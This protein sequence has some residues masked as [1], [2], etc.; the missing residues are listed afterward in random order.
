[1]KLPVQTQARPRTFGYLVFCW[2]R[3]LLAGINI[4]YKHA[5]TCI[6]FY[7]L[8]DIFS[9]LHSMDVLVSNHPILILTGTW[10]TT[11]FI[12]HCQEVYVQPYPGLLLSSHTIH[13]QVHYP[14]SV[15]WKNVAFADC[16]SWPPL[17]ETRVEH[18]F[19]FKWITEPWAQLSI[20][21]LVWPILTLNPLKLNP[22]PLPCPYSS[23]HC[24]IWV[25]TSIS[26]DKRYS[27]I[28]YCSRGQKLVHTPISG[29]PQTVHHT[30]LS[31]V[32]LNPEEYIS[33]KE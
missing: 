10:S 13:G 15:H 4:Q 22:Y 27:Q 21:H 16:P 12:D 28:L 11:Q 9:S 25:T 26:Q 17:R 6:H 19:I 2:K 24:F 29:I 23:P 7:K 14:S 20:L 30:I 33:S 3:S 32:Q 18:Q 5:H 1:M 8:L 31:Q